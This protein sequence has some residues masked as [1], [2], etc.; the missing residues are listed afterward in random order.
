MTE[1]LQLSFPARPEALAGLRRELQ[2]F[3]YGAVDQGLVDSVK[4]A[5]NELVTNSIVHGYAGR[6]PG[7]AEVTVSIRAATI[8]VRVRDFGRGLGAASPNAGAGLGRAMVARLADAVVEHPGASGGHD[9]TV[10]FYSAGLT[11][12]GSSVA[13]LL[14]H[15]GDPRI[16]VG[17]VPG[18]EVIS[19]RLPMKERF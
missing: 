8:C 14:D 18:N 11:V 15:G 9:V 6:L 10:V 16:A 4:L 5:V 1:P 17:F 12:P 19:P 2:E 7:R 13:A 3:L